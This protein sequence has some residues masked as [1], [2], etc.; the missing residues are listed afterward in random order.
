MTEAGETISEVFV[1]DLPDDVTQPGDGP[2]AGT[3]SRMPYPPK[4]AAQRRLTYTV[5]QKHRG[6]QGP[7]HW[8]HSSPDG[9]RIAFMMKDNDGVVQLYTVSPNGG[10]KVQVTRNPWSIT[11]TFTWSPD[12]REIAYV[13]DNSVC[14][15][16][17]ATGRTRRLTRRTNDATAPRGEACV[18]SADGKRIAYLRQ[19]TERGKAANQIFVLFLDSEAASV[20]GR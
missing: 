11:S 15:T 14:I 1:V 19:L 4:N 6:I 2:L 17:V 8:L 3:E 10:E 20:T 12:G 18:F 7:R 9:T 5:N 13:M 16:E